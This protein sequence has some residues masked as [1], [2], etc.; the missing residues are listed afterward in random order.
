MK[1][2]SESN[3]TSHSFGDELSGSWKMSP[4]RF[5]GRS[6]ANELDADGFGC[7]PDY[8]PSLPTLVPGGD[9]GRSQG[10]ATASV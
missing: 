10:R 4:A 5:I 6:R 1:K 9:S 8:F 7:V 2:F 3:A